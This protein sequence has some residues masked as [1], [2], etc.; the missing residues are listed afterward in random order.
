MQTSVSVAD[1]S[2]YYLEV[3]ISTAKH[4]KQIKNCIIPQ[5]SVNFLL[6]K[7]QNRRIEEATLLHAVKYDL[8]TSMNCTSK[9]HQL[10]HSDSEISKNITCGKT[11]AIVNTV[12]VPHLVAMAIRDLN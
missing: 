11:K 3:H 9:L 1:R 7:I 4:K 10:I 5:R 6:N 2:S 8:P 12:L